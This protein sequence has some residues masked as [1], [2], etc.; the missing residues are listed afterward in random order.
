MEVRRSEINISFPVDMLKFKPSYSSF[1]N[2]IKG[3]GMTSVIFN[4][5][6]RKRIFKE[7]TFGHS[8]EES[9]GLSKS[10]PGGRTES[11]NALRCVLGITQRSIRLGYK[12]EKE[13]AQR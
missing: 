10:A 7:V 6:R 4:I 1:R 8:L 12:K 2:R 13:C 9:E 5:L 11:T 3:K